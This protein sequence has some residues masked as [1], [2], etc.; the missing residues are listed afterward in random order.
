[1]QQRSPRHKIASA[2]LS[3]PESPRNVTIEINQNEK[4]A[5]TEIEDDF[6]D[7]DDPF[8]DDYDIEDYEGLD[9]DE[10]WN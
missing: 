7:D 4:D 5:G 3:P 2:L 8:D 6:D 9:F 1:M 10:N